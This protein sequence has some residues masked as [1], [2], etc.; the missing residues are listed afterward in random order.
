MVGW[1]LFRLFMHYPTSK[2]SLLKFWDALTIT[3]QT[4]KHF[5]VSENEIYINLFS[6]AL[7]FLQSKFEAQA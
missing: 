6:K 1:N 4:T 3:N 2:R 7:N 5:G